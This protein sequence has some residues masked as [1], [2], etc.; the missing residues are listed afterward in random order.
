MTYRL[1]RFE[2]RNFMGI[3]ALDIAFGETVTEISG[4]NGAGKSSTLTGLDITFRGMD[5]AP[6]EPI[7][8][9][10]DQ[11]FIR[12]HLAGDPNGGIILTRKFHKDGSGKLVSGLRITTPEGALIPRPQEHLDKIIG[13]HILDPFAFINMKEQQQFDVLRAFVP[14]FDFEANA[15][16]E[17]GDRALRTDEGRDRDRERAAADSIHVLLEPPCE[18]IDEAALTKELQEAGEKNA[19]LERRR[20]GREQHLQ[21]ID[22]AKRAAALNREQAAELRRQADEHD[23]RAATKEAEAAE[24]QKQYDE[25]EPL[26]ALIDTTA[27]AARL[28]EARASNKKLEDWE[29]Q[30]VLK[31]QHARK[32]DEHGKKYDELTERIATHK[33]AREDAI[34]KSHLP[35]DGLGFGEGFITWKGVRF[36]QASTGQQLRTAFAISVASR[37]E[38][39]LCWIR[40]ASLLDANTRKTCDEL[41]KEFKAQVIYETVSPTN[42]SAIELEDGHLKGMPVPVEEPPQFELSAEPAAAT[43]KR[44]RPRWQGPGAPTGEQP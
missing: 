4:P 2:G 39:P 24:M 17:A 43:Q 40:N 14:G 20:I 5:V 35:V 34:R 3:V 27:L 6:P 31:Q 29:R 28:S 19:Q 38:F 11:S 12:S 37:P 25:A 44:A 33:A 9:G 23:R 15:R 42:D 26:P 41:A 8:L 13:D 30:R 7:R 21:K 36:K 1:T 10:A 32:A 16:K 18:R 22:D